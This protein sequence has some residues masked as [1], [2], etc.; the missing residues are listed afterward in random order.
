MVTESMSNQ[1]FVMEFIK[2]NKKD[3]PLDN[4][5]GKKVKTSCECL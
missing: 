4:M 3:K 2:I 5:K 1:N